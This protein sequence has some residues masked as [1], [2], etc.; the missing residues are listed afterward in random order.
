MKMDVNALKRLRSLL[1]PYSLL[2]VEDNAGL[3]AQAGMM[4]TKLFDTFYSAADG[5]E[6]LKLFKEHRPQIVITDVAMPRMDGMRMAELI[7]QIEPDT[8]I[9]IATA[10]DEIPL[11]HRS[12]ELGVFDYLIKPLK[13]DTILET[14]MR[15][16]NVLDGARHQKIFNMNLHTVFNYQNNLLLLLH[17]HT[18]VMANQP[19]LDFFGVTTVEELKNKFKTFDQLLLAHNGFLYNHNEIDWFD[20][21]SSH[22]G[23]LFNTKIATIDGVPHHFILSF[24]SIPEKEGYSVLSFNDVTELGLLKLYDPN[25][26]ER[27]RL[28]KD[29]K[30]VRGLLEMAMRNGAK[31]KVHNFY[32]GLTI[33]ND[34]LIVTMEEKNVSLKTPYIQLK[35]IQ[36][37]DTFYLTSDLFPMSIEAKGIQRIDFDD[38][39]VQFSHYTLAETSPIRRDTIRVVPDGTLQVTILY[40]GR[41]YE[42]DVKILDVSIQGMRVEFSLLP[43]GFAAN[44]QVILDMVITESLRPI[45]IN[46]AATVFRITEANHRFEV[47][48]FYELHAQGKKALIDYVAKRQLV[49]IREFKGLQL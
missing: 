40:E 26:V 9:I 29:E 2:Y 44:N 18:V 7:L 23:K 37:S 25:A 27:E 14:L 34:G 22:T 47:V 17:A 12:I 36:L 4:F 20:E 38:Q 41:K 24:Q 15:C 31:V 11:L 39:S 42:S 43:S 19:C 33:T 8:K 49:L 35:A 5:E 6:G 1:H 32:K 28:S 46:T 16:V 45:I 30:I 48:F 10:H 3:S 21:I 13:L